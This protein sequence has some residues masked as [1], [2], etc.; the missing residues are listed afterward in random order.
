MCLESAVNEAE[1][2]VTVCVLAA[3]D[4]AAAKDTLG[5]VAY[6]S[7]CDIVINSF[8]LLALKSVFARA[9]Q[10]SNIEQLALAVLVTLLAVY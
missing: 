6:D 10:L 2:A 8:C 5:C 1:D 4:T 7:R 3:L 9:G